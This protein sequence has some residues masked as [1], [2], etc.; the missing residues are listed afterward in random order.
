MSKRDVLL[1]KRTQ[2]LEQC[3]AQA[4]HEKGKLSAR[5]RISLLFDKDSFHEISAFASPSEEHPGDGVIVGYGRIS[6]RTVY[7]S[8][9]DFSCLG[10]SVGRIHASKICKV[11]DL[12]GEAGCPFISVNDSGGAR[13]DEGIVALNGYGDIFKRNVK[14]SGVVPQLAVILGPAAGGACYSPALMDAVFLC[15]PV[16]KMFLTGP[17]VAKAVLFQDYSAEELGG[18]NMHMEKSGVAHYAYDTEEEC[19]S[20]VRKYLDYLLE[21]RL[22]KFR[23]PSGK[24]LATLVPE[25]SRKSYDMKSVIAE[26]VDKDSFFEEKELYARNSITG[27]AR[28]GGRS[29]GIVANQP[30]CYSGSL[31]YKAAMKI[32]RFVQF[33]DAFRLPVITLVDVPAFMPGI[34]QERSGIIRHGAKVLF[35][36][37][38]ATVPLVTVILRKAFGGAYIAMGSKSLGADFV[39]AWPTAEIAVMGAEGAVSILHRRKIK[40][41]SPDDVHQLEKEYREKYYTPYEAEKALLVDEVILPEETRDRIIASLEAIAEKKHSPV[42]HRNMPL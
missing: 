17:D 28:I 4:Q 26:L 16:S 2:T 11:M 7:A 25:N 30:L 24:E 37:S 6:G 10:G 41:M 19:F 32:A 21:P 35:S 39:F 5:E 12:A 29:V 36:Y 40:D 22:E 23:Q 38:N 8:F 20:G 33:C 3:R 9:D 1:R 13:I 42:N 14:L 15:K 27:F 31:D 18:W 34:D